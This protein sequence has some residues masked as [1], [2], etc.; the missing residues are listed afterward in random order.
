MGFGK[1]AHAKPWAWHPTDPHSEAG[2]RASRTAMATEGRPMRGIGSVWTFYR[3]AF[4]RGFC[5]RITLLGLLTLALALSAGRVGAAFGVPLLF[6]HK[7]LGKQ[8]FVGVVLAVLVAGIL[9][10]SYLIDTKRKRL[11][12]ELLPDDPGAAVA[13]YVGGILVSYF[14]TVIV[15][16]AVLAGFARL[17]EQ[18]NHFPQP[19]VEPDPSADRLP[20]PGP[21]V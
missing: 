1:H 14:A 9:L 3:D 20:F 16:I 4:L 11:W 7:D 21:L 6:W 19:N 10:T 5:T 18:L 17:A 13:C 8:A 15:I 2:W 12:R